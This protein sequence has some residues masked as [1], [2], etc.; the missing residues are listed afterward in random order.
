MGAPGLNG[1]AHNGY[2]FLGDKDSGLFS[3]AANEVSLYVNNAEEV[4]VRPDLVINRE[5]RPENLRPEA[6]RK[7]KL[8]WPE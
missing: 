8:Q 4:Q 5:V 1:S 6:R 3:T 7:D 2:G